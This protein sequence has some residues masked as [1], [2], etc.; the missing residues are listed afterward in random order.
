MVSHVHNIVRRIELDKAEEIYQRLI[1]P[2]EQKMIL[3]ITRIVRDPDDAADVLQEVL[4]VIWRKLRRIDCHPNPHAY[5]LRICLTRSIDSIR[6]RVRQ[7]EVSL[8]IEKVSVVPNEMP[9][10]SAAS[11]KATAIRQAIGLL[12]HN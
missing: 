4:A 3:T 7:R 10:H 8:E 2:I 11:E 5:I 6:R 9:G 12:P 1:E